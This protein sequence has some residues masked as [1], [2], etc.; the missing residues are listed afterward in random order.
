M[1]QGLAY[2]AQKFIYYASLAAPDP[3][4]TLIWLDGARL[5]LYLIAHIPSLFIPQFVSSVVNLKHEWLC[6]AQIS[7]NSI[8][9]L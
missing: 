9:I 1:V 7:L 4:L 8:D 3:S 6:G 5:L 2:Y